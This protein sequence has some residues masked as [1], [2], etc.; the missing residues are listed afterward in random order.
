MRSSRKEDKSV[1]DLQRYIDQQWERTGETANTPAAQHPVVD[2]SNDALE[3]ARRGSLALNS[4]RQMALVLTR[5]NESAS[6]LIL[7]EVRQLMVELGF[8]KASLLEQLEIEFAASYWAEHHLA[9]MMY[10]CTLS[11][12]VDSRKAESWH[13]RSVNAEK[14]YRQAMKALRSLQRSGGTTRTAGAPSS[15]T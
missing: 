13:R 14:R 3:W 4:M 10:A 9:K 5:G 15:K 6:R 12:G 7:E 2:P 1:Q 11:A 8:E